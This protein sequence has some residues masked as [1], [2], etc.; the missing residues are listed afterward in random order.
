MLD[1]EKRN[2]SV[3]GT[4]V[5]CPWWDSAADTEPAKGT[6]SKARRGPRSPK[7]PDYARPGGHERKL[8]AKVGQ[9]SL[10]FWGNVWA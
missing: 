1:V 6:D 2:I 7:R 3:R 10:W 4:I 5:L 8:L 9:P